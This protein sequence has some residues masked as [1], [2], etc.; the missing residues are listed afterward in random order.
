MKFAGRFSGTKYLNAEFGDWG[1]LET[2]NLQ[3]FSDLSSV[4]D[5]TYRIPLF[6]AWCDVEPDGP[7]ERRQTQP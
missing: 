5:L 2:I 4:Y 7:A 1:E 6:R 3:I